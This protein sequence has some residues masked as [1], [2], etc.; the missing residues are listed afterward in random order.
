MARKQSSC[1]GIPVAV[2]STER[3]HLITP[4]EKVAI[5][6]HWTR[7]EGC[8]ILLGLSKESF[9]VCF[10]RKDLKVPKCAT[11]AFAELTKKTKTKLSF[12]LRKCSR[13]TKIIVWKCCTDPVLFSGMHL[14]FSPSCLAHDQILGFLNR[15]WWSSCPGPH[16]F[17]LNQFRALVTA[18][19][20]RSFGLDLDGYTEWLERV[21]PVRKQRPVQMFQS[22]LMPSALTAL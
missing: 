6:Q 15:N 21:N 19:G 8:R 1:P 16:A 3:N 2:Y 11:W 7:N 17:S 14:A 5:L 18:E 22:C 20:P 9:F 12:D 4:L 10:L 13:L